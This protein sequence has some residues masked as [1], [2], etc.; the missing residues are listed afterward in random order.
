MALLVPAYLNTSTGKVTRINAGT[1]FIN[2]TAGGTGFG[3]YTVADLLYA[4]TT[5]T[6]AK[7]AIG[8]TGQALIVSGGLPAWGVTLIAGGGTG[9]SSYTAGDTLH[10]VSG[11]ALTKLAIGSTG[12]VSVVV[13]GVPAWGVGLIAGGGT[14]LSS[15]TAGDM[16]YYAAST[17]LSKLAI[18]SANYILTSSGTAP[19]WS[20]PSSLG[21][22]S[23]S[24]TTGSTILKFA[25]VYS[26]AAGE[27][28]K[29]QANSTSTS[30][31]IG[32]TA[33]A[34]NTATSGDVYTIAGTVV[35][36]T[37]GE[38]DAVAG[39]SGGLTFNTRYYLST[40]TP[41]LIQSTVPSTA[42]HTIYLVGTAISTTKIRL[43]LQTIGVL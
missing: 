34:I 11:T 29:A 4:D 14:G 28:T 7:L 31:V 10:Y 15:Y 19:Q 38:W 6:L 35:T 13:G 41:G 32:I 5:T 12:Q 2:P 18:G 16:L 33:A 24:N 9:V 30:E 42:G 1:D 23:L 37:T 25:A 20:D 21:V 36:G 39:T 22:S 17:A 43:A 8:S 40:A 26:S 27:I 3:A